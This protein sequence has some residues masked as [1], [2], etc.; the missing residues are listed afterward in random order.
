MATSSTSTSS[1]TATASRPRAARR[2]RPPP[3]W[4]GLDVARGLAVVL[5][6]VLVVGALLAPEAL[7]PTAWRGLTLVDLLPG[8]FLVIAGAG[9][10]WRHDSGVTWTPRRRWRRAGVLVAAGALVAVARADAEPARLAADELLRLAA[11]TG[12]AAVARRLPGWLL[13]PLTGALLLAPAALVTGDPLGR[14]LPGVEPAR[15]W[16]LEA[17]LGLPTGEVPVVSLPAAVALVLIGH[18]LGTWAHRRPPGPATGAAFATVGVWCLLA[19]I[20]VGQVVAPVP[21]LLDLPVAAA[22]TGLAALV[23]A[24]GHLA[25]AWDG[26]PGLGAV[27][28]VALPLVVA[29][30]VA[31]ATI[32]VDALPTLPALAALTAGGAVAAAAVAIAR[33]LDRPG[34]TLRA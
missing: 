13:V 19:T 20:V 18:G 21:R 26:L 33:L 14:G 16:V 10:G 17:A 23:L 8:L 28:R 31:L 22:A 5:A 34:W 7:G 25:A 29:G 3:R 4:E 24:A 1:R 27:G 30:T 15:G 9:A 2:R 32:P 12:L 11:A 6:A